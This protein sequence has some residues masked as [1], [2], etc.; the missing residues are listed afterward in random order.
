MKSN[1]II[2]TALAVLASLPASLP[3]ADMIKAN[4]TTALN[5]PG[6]WVGDAVPGPSDIA[7]WDSTVSGPLTNALG[8]NLAWQGLRIASPG[9]IIAIANT[10]NFLTNGTA[11]LNMAAATTDFAFNPSLAVGANQTWDIAGGRTLFLWTI[12]TAR[13]TYG[14]RSL[15]FT[16]SAGG[17]DALVSM[18][19]GG[20]GSTGFNDVG[21]NRDF[22]G[23]WIIGSGVVVRNIRQG[24]TAWGTNN[25]LILA[26]GTV[27]P[28]QGNWTWTTPIVA[29]AGSSST[30]DNKNTSGSNRSLK[31]QGELS[32][33]GTLTFAD[34]GVG[35]NSENLGYIL[36]GSNTLS[37][38]VNVASG[39]EV[40]IGGV[41]GDNTSTTAGAGGS[42]GTAAVVNDGLLTF[43]RNNEITVPNN[44]SG[45]G[46][47]RFGNYNVAGGGGQ[48]VKLTGNNS[49]TGT[50]QL[51][52]G[53]VLFATSG[54]IP[55]SMSFFNVPFRTSV[56]VGIPLDQTFL[57]RL[58]AT[59]SGTLA[60][61]ANSANA[62]DFSTQFGTLTLGS[63]GTNTYSGALTPNS[64][65]G[66]LTYNYRL[67]GAGGTLVVSAPLGDHSGAPTGLIICGGGTE[68]TVI[69]NATN[70]F[71]G[72]VTI[73]GGVVID[74]TG[75]GFGS[76]NLNLGLYQG[77]GVFNR[78]LGAGANQVRVVA[79]NSGFS[80]YGGP[81]NVNLGGAGAAVAFDSPNFAPTV[82]VLN[83]VQADSPLTFANGLDLAGGIREVNVAATNSI[84]TATLAAPISN[85]LGF[86]GL[87]KSGVGTLVLGSA[88]SLGGE[89]QLAGGTVSVGSEASLGTASD[90]LNFNGGILRVTGTS[91]TSFGSRVVYWSSFNGGLDIADAANTFTVN[92]AMYG[93]GA[94]VKAGPGLLVLGGDSQRTG[95]TTILEGAIRLTHP[96]ALA[97]SPVSINTN[98]GLQINF[99]DAPMAGIA[100]TGAVDF[101]TNLIT[102]TPTA[103]RTYSGAVS[104]S[105]KIVLAASA[106]GIY[107]IYAGSNS[108]PFS[109]TYEVTNSLFVFNGTNCLDGKPALDVLADPT[110][111]NIGIVLG[112][113]L[114]GRSASFKR[115]SGGGAVR[116]DWGLAGDPRTLSVD[117]GV[118]TV[119]SGVISLDQ[120]QNIRQISLEKLG[121]GKLTLTGNNT[122]RGKTTVVGGTLAL[123]GTGSLSNSVLVDV[124]AGATLDVSGLA[125]TPFVL[126]ATQT[127]Q[128]NGTVKG[129]LQADGTLAPGAS[130]GKLTVNGAVTLN[131]TTTMEIGK[132]GGT[133][134]DALIAAGTLTF[135][136]SLVVTNLGPDALA[137]GDRFVL[138]SAASRIG[139]FASLTLPA[140]PAGLDWTNKLALDGSL[141]VIATVST[142]PVPMQVTVVGGQ[143]LIGWPAD[144]TGWQLQTQ[145]N[146]LSVGLS[147]NWYPWPGSTTTNAATVPIDPANPSVFLRL[148]YPPQ[149]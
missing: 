17:G 60:L 82:L 62:L 119:Y 114:N 11:G 147:G 107:Q 108:F 100:G 106:T 43:T 12:N 129:D 68:G 90:T 95:L 148:I 71:T 137:A 116:S 1:R 46:T 145:T 58:D 3:A 39:A 29:Q 113:A 118:D 34:T 63:M 77:N 125:A 64:L 111:F 45:G 5:L 94:L 117:Q 78:A 50:A 122:Y 149:P 140:L 98:H 74:A 4:N 21:G 110:N 88:N 54:A 32:G 126:G 134:N 8:T 23:N 48:L 44:L 86:G 132:S 105:G 51:Q 66:G 47:F 89:L 59:S 27:G 55:G 131:G 144:H 142:T 24:R 123:A 42:L 7:V 115:L 31:L 141:E 73:L 14:S 52:T 85:S 96:N 130:I 69:L 2:P 56:G 53:A 19:P 80:T 65:D 6:S 93:A 104:G 127:L 101:G 40:R 35:M 102:L 79:G 84:A 97:G 133:T 103:N 57:N 75:F 37:G 121:A 28:W 92:D 18:Q 61:A 9:G 124:A 139:S 128:G 135:G 49:W 70:T 143:L 76:G 30:I 67:G 99:N 10:A 109:G 91:L 112:D 33:A 83:A 146:A 81:L 13:G 41:P 138:F 26:G 38:T 136:G 15:A 87:T 36:T 16:N 25:S 22:T 72:P 20:S 120:A